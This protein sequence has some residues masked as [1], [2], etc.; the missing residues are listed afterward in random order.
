[1][2]KRQALAGGWLVARRRTG[3]ECE[4]GCRGC[5]L[6]RHCTLPD[7]EAARRAGPRG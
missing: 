5:P 4:R 3:A 1:V 6:L 7:A 2:Y